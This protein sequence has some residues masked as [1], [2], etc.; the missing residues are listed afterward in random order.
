MDGGLFM[1]HQQM[2]Q[3][4]LAVQGVVQGQHGAAGIAEHS[5]DAVSQQGRDQRLRA[6]ERRA[7][8]HAATLP[9]IAQQRLPDLPDFWTNSAKFSE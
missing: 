8:L 7:C 2:A 9:R 3:A 4:R 1:P 6:V 5:V